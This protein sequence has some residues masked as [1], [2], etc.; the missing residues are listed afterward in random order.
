MLP[1]PAETGVGLTPPLAHNN[2]TA[3]DSMLFSIMGGLIVLVWLANAVTCL[4]LL[5]SRRLSRP[6][7]SGIRFGL[8]G[9]LISMGIGMLMIMNVTAAQSAGRDGDNRG[10]HT[11]GASDGGPGLP[12][13]G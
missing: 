1:H 8:V 2:A 13:V 3:L 11:V 5:R 10:A 6:L 9:S 7:T 4:A 12:V